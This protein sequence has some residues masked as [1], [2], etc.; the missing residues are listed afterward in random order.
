MSSHNT[1]NSHSFE[2]PQNSSNHD[3]IK[4]HVET[5][6]ETEQPYTYPT[7]PAHDL[8]NPDSNNKYQSKPNGK[9]SPQKVPRI[10]RKNSQQNFDKRQRS[11]AKPNPELSCLDPDF[12]DP[13][14]FFENFD[15]LFR[16]RDQSDDN[17]VP[18][19]VEPAKAR[20]IRR[21]LLDDFSL[22]P[23]RPFS[24]EP[25]SIL[26]ER[27]SAKPIPKK[28]KVLPQLDNVS[29]RPSY[30]VST[31]YQIPYAKTQNNQTAPRDSL[32]KDMTVDAAKFV[33]QP[34]HDKDNKLPDL[35]IPKVLT[36]KPSS[37]NKL[38]VNGSER[39]VEKIQKFHENYLQKNKPRTNVVSKTPVNAESV[40]L[41]LKNSHQAL[42]DMLKSKKVDLNG[43][44]S[45]VMSEENKIPDR[46][47]NNNTNDEMRTRMNSVQNIDKSLTKQ[48]LQKNDLSLDL[49]NNGASSKV[50]F[51]LKN[52]EQRTTGYYQGV[53]NKLSN[54]IKE[55]TK[56]P[57]ITSRTHYAK[58]NISML[59]NSTRDKGLEG[60]KL[61]EVKEVA[62]LGVRGAESYATT[63]NSQIHSNSRVKVGDISQI[64][65]GV[66]PG[67]KVKGPLK[68]VKN[69]RM[70][71]T[72]GMPLKE[73][74]EH[75]IDTRSTSVPR[76]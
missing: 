3:G 35:K 72:T 50:K 75:N 26:Q 33:S 38:P 74:Y 66:R 46:Q 54:G 24:C 9:S 18:P 51:I 62:N 59:S 23:S 42:Q 20:N 5:E 17:I 22:A 31:E 56:N 55:S 64:Y 76:R 73:I 14:N 68:P 40:A 8:S 57:N 12:A 36:S 15:K 65:K 32:V 19:S 60:L 45:T 4:G 2:N 52:L 41:R 21:I 1:E 27:L 16:I 25:D 28:E 61:K 43:R 53:I 6:T 48:A 44:H 67:I 11:K 70:V 30:N 69:I 7:S 47:I 37:F 34:K 10:Y 49:G 63:K 71:T 39:I 13:D 58:E 29:H